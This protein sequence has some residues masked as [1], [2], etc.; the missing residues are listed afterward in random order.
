MTVRNR[1]FYKGIVKKML[2]ERLTKYEEDGY[3]YSLQYNSYTNSYCLYYTGPG[4]KHW[5][6]CAAVEVSEV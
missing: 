2:T 5:G 4:E 6:G 3:K 1:D